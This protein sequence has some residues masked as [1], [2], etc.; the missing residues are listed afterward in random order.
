[1]VSITDPN[2]RIA[3]EKQLGK[4]PGAPIT[5]AEMRLLNELR[6][7]NSNIAQLTGLESA[8]NLK[9]LYLGVEYVSAEGRLINSNSTSDLSPLSGLTDLT[10]LDLE[11]NAITDISPLEDLTH[12]L[13]LNL[14]ENLVSDIPILSGLTNLVRLWLWD[15]LISDI[16]TL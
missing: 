6:A 10:L 16:S 13:I 8:V 4:S 3:I 7:S 5:M 9:R 11:R 15:N 12:L 2:L 14:G 1:M